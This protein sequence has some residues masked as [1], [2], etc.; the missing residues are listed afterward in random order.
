MSW[1]R[2]KPGV[3]L[4]QFPNISYLWWWWC[5]EIDNI[6]IFLGCVDC[7]HQTCMKE[8]QQSKNWQFPE[9]PRWMQAVQTFYCLNQVGLYSVLSY[10]REVQITTA[11]S[12]DL[13][14][15]ASSVSILDFQKGGGS[16]LLSS[17][18][19]LLFMCSISNHFF[20]YPVIPT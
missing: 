15:T 13:F 17:F 5:K 16:P 1:T 2:H 9:R 4:R 12:V 20:A 19:F 10:I 18:P 11:K 8:I 14:Q 3:F 7:S 6:M